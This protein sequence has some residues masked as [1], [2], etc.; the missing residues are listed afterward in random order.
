MQSLESKSVLMVYTHNELLSEK[1]NDSLLEY[2]K[3]Q[4][5]RRLRMKV[6]SPYTVG[7]DHFIERYY[8]K[9]YASEYL[10]LLYVNPREFS[11]ESHV[12]IYDDKVSMI[13]LARDEHIGVTIE[14][15]AYADTSRAA[16]NLS[17]LGATS[18][19]AQ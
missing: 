4:A 10:E 3:Q 2:G 7:I 5:A 14:S 17:W 12:V 19:V 8:S 6:I 16:F 18:F 1:F 15:R 11:L 13:S 9:E